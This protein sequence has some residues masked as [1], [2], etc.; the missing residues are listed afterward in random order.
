[1]SPHDYLILSVF[2]LCLLRFLLLFASVYSLVVFFGM[3]FYPFGRLDFPPGFHTSNTSFAT[4]VHRSPHTWLKRIAPAFLV[5]SVQTLLRAWTHMLPFHS[6][7]WPITNGRLNTSVETFVRTPPSYLTRILREISSRARGCS[8]LPPLFTKSFSGTPLGLPPPSDPSAVNG[9]A[10]FWWRK[11]G[12]LF[13]GRTSRL[14]AFS[15]YL[16]SRSCSAYPVG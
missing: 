1:M 15:A 3:G 13:S 12:C 10:R 11:N 5:A 16:L 6:H 2:S 4:T 14:D 8:H 7:A 9:S